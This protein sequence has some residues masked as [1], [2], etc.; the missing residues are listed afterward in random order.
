MTTVCGLIEDNKVWMG[1]DSFAIDDD[2]QYPRINTKVFTK[3][4]YLI[5][6]AGSYRLGQLLMYKTGFPK[7][8]KKGDLFGFMCTDF[9]DHAIEVFR[10][11]GYLKDGNGGEIEIGGSFLVGVKKTGRL[12]VVDT[13]LHVG[14]VE[15]F[16]AIGAGS[17]IATGALCVAS[18]LDWEPNIKVLNALLAAEKFVNGTKG[19]FT[20]LDI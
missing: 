3:G 18:S 8:T 14:E 9:I 2:H 6:Y 11:N 15:H 5:G 17:L 1:A 12:F 20:I 13:D 4:D 10:Q 7:P 19:P 16:E